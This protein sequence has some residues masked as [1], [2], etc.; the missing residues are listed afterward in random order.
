MAARKKTAK[1][2]A[3][4]RTQAARKT[5]KKAAK[6]A[7][8][9][10]K[11]KSTKKAAAAKTVK[12]KSTK[13]A[14]AAKTRKKSTRRSAA[15]SAVA[16]AGA[17]KPARRKVRKSTSPEALLTAQFADTLLHLEDRLQERI[18]G[19]RSAIE[20]IARIIRIT[21]TELDFRPERP[22][23]AF[24]LVG[25]EGVGKNEIAYAIG[26][27]LQGSEDAVVSIDLGEV[28][29]EEDVAK[30]GATLVPGSE[31]HFLPG[32]LT[33]PVRENPKTILLL[34]GLE[35]AH[36][37]FHRLLL[38]ILERG[39]IDDMIG[40]VH[41]DQT[42]IFVTLTLT[43]EELAPQEIG[44][45]R[46]SKSEEDRLRELLGRFVMPDLLDA[47]NEVLELPPLSVP[48]VRQIA[49]YKVE[50]VIRRMA[51]KRKDIA[52][53]DSVFDELITDELCRDG[54]AKF[55]N[56]TLQERL[57]NPLARFLLTHQSTS[58]IS[59]D[60]T[61]GSVVIDPQERKS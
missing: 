2:A 43:R 32:M 13:K 34:R 22:N 17:R 36:P 30:L 24:L 23:G 44:F 29:E 6:K 54:G 10:V 61:K 51:K 39:R 52:I 53:S 45:G 3:S 7:A 35:Q 19:K 60:F 40:P 27:V 5:A 4:T 47:F 55:L 16:K 37:T 26:E 8:G 12:K 20:S 58:Q 15:K 25:P 9:T 38:T 59:I 48:E 56:R 18:V 31:T 33:H 42:L 57:F 11:K 41:F 28:A 21:G 49:R 14:A 50:R 1:K 46:P